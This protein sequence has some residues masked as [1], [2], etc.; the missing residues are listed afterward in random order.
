MF[1]D[2]EIKKLKQK[3]EDWVHEVK[4]LE[5][6][7]MKTSFNGTKKDKETKAYIH[8]E[9]PE[10]SEVVDNIIDEIKYQEID[11]ARKKL[12]QLAC[13]EIRSNYIN[14][15]TLFYK[16]IEFAT[17]ALLV[18]RPAE[19]WNASNSTILNFLNYFTTET[20]NIVSYDYWFICLQTLLPLVFHL[21][22][23][24][25]SPCCLIVPYPFI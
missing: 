16:L 18:I 10:W 17:I 4:A 20:P 11:Q 21:Q 23:Y 7:V 6:E 24:F 25:Y 14:N 19:D 5:R 12:K 8:E 9:S 2:K 1:L 15:F 3:E 13:L 22:A